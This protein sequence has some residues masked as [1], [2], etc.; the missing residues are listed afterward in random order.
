[1][2]SFRPVPAIVRQLV[3]ASE[4]CVMRVYDDARPRYVLQPGDHALGTLTAGRGHTGPDV[5]MGMNVTPQDVDAWEDSDLASAARKVCAKLTQPALDRLTDHEYGALCDF[6]FNCGTPGTTI[7]QDLNAGR[8]ADVP[9]QLALFD[10]GV[11]GGHMIKIPGLDHRRAAEVALW[12]TPDVPADHPDPVAAQAVIVAAA[13]APLQAAA[14]AGVVAPPS[15]VTREMDTP[16]RPVGEPLHAKG[17][18]QAACLAATACAAHLAQNAPDVVDK[19]KGCVDMLKGVL[20]DQVDAA[21]KLGTILEVIGYAGVACAL[22]VPIAMMVRDW[23]QR[24]Q[25]G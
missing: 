20:G 15:S 6:G 14:D 4:G 21:P 1:M 2:A 13:T 17:P 19:L 7:W 5:V 3:D 25:P 18:F 12:N 10:H 8:L 23:G 22:A 11:V 16:P 24:H 9:A